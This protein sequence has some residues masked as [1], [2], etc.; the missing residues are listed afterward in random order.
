MLQI[1]KKT[2]ET[3]NPPSPTNSPNQRNEEAMDLDGPST[4]LEDIP[5]RHSSPEIVA[6]SKKEKIRLLIKEHVNIWKR[7]EKEKT[8]G[9]TTEL[10]S[11][12]HQA[13]DSQKV[14]QRMITKEE[15]EGYV[16][17]WNPWTVKRE[18]FPPPPKKEGKKRSSTSTK[19]QKFD[20]PKV[21]AEV[22]EIGQAWRA[23][24]KQRSR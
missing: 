8:S 23:A 14:L 13:Q 18:L 24:Y 10:K 4:S 16:K 17:G 11:I 19:A 21:W 1:K 7:F 15:L 12:L 3:I 22:F 2:A 6:L 9:A 5:K 20:D